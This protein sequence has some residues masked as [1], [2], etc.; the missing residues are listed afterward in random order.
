M[1]SSKWPM[2]LSLCVNVLVCVSCSLLYVWLNVGFWLLTLWS[3]PLYLNTGGKDALTV[4]FMLAHV[5][6]FQPIASWLIKHRLLAALLVGWQLKVLQA[7]SHRRFIETKGHLDRS[8]SFALRRHRKMVQTKEKISTSTLRL[9]R[10]KICGLFLYIFIV[11]NR[12]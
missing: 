7:T 5:Y 9:E 6:V 11:L 4:S 3:E 12:K 2:L 1:V 8:P 10:Q